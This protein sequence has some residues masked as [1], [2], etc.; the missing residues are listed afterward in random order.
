MWRPWGIISNDSDESPAINNDR[1]QERGNVVVQEEPH[2]YVKKNHNSSSIQALSKQCQELICN[3]YAY[4]KE[5]NIGKGHIT[6][7]A[8]AVKLS[9]QTV[10]KIVNR[11]PKTPRKRGQKRL[12]FEKIDDSTLD[13]IR[14]EIHSFYE[15]GQSRT[16]QELLVHLQEICQFPYKETHL[17]GLLKKLGFRFCR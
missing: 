5:N 2:K 10:S 16:V 17:R 4:M 15:K 1:P 3:V 14:R 12:R 9:R 7:T 6:E 8:K 13:L 11:G